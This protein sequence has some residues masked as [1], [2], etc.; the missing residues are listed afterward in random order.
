MMADRSDQ[1]I[2]EFNNVTNNPTRSGRYSAST[3]QT[4]EKPFVANGWYPEAAV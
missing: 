1:P 3:Q 2:V 4:T